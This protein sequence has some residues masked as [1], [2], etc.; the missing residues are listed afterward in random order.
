VNQPQT[1]P[2]TVPSPFSGR[3]DR[4]RQTLHAAR[5]N[6][7]L[8]ALEAS[9][10]GPPRARKRDSTVAELCEVYAAAVATIVD[11]MQRIAA[12]DNYLGVHVAAIL[13]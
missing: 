12:V 4:R 5:I 11:L 6:G 8:R 13:R 2:P 3:G 7:E 9:T 1:I 10:A